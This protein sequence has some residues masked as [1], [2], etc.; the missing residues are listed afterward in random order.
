MRITTLKIEGRTLIPAL[1]MAMTKGEAL[2]SS[3][4]DPRRRL[5][6]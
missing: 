2:A 1:L 4:E 6:P 3:D 5:S